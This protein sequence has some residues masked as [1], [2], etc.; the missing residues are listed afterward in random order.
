MTK[1]FYAVKCPCGHA[2][3]KSWF[4]DPA[5]AV[6][7]VSFTEE[8]A[9]AVAGFLNRRQQP[10]P[11]AIVKRWEVDW[12]VCR[13]DRDDVAYEK[14]RAK[15]EGRKAAYTEAGAEMWRMARGIGPITAEH[16]HWGGLLLELDKRQVDW[17]TR[18]CV[19][20]EAAGHPFPERVS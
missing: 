16:A 6:Q 2:S 3:C 7:G 15:E 19:S 18:A 10:I 20:Y 5:A 1:T 17:V 14:Q 9:R 11:E 13:A 4:V 8:E 12:Y